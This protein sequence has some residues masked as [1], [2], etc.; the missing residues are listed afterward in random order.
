MESRTNTAGQH[1]HTDQ[2][3]SPNSQTFPT[4]QSV[5]DRDRTDLNVAN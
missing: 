3:P 2:Q 5:N 1:H 4:D